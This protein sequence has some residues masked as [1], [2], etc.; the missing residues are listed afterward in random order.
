MSPT[1]I[2]HLFAGPSRF[3]TPY[4][5]S[6]ACTPDGTTVWRPPARRGDID[7]LVRECA[8]PGI[9][10]LADGTFHTYPSV[11]H[12][13][14]RRATESGW[15]VYGLCSMGAIRASEM[16]HLG[17]RPFGRVAQM[18]RDDP[19]L[20]DDEVALVHGA[21]EP[22]YP[23]S[24]PMVHIRAYL[25]HMKS[26][27]LLDTPEHAE[28]VLA[29]REQWYAGRTLARLRVDLQNIARASAL[30]DLLTSLDRFEPY[31]LKQQDLLRFLT[32]KPW[33]DEAGTVWQTQ[34]LNPGNAP[35]AAS[36]VEKPESTTPT[37]ALSSS[38]R[39]RTAEESLALVGPLAAE[40]GVS[41]VVDITWLDR[42][43][44]PV[45]ASIRP[46]APEHSLNVHAGKGS[47]H[48]EAKIGAYME[49][50]E[51]SFAELGRSRVTAHLAT[52]LDILDSFANTIDFIDFCPSQHYPREVQ[53]EDSIG[54]IEAEELLSLHRTVLVPAEL[55]HHPYNGAPG[56]H[57]YTS[58]T[59]G[60]ASGNTIAEAT[61]HGLAEVMERH[62][63]S[64]LTLGATSYWVDPATLSPPLRAMVQRF[65]S[66]GLEVHLRYAPNDFGLAYLS[67]SVFEDGDSPAAIS[68]GMGFHCNSDIAAIRA[69][70]EAAQSRLTTIHGGRD[71]LV[72]MH[73]LFD[74]LGRE[75]EQAMKAALRASTSDRTN[76][77]A[78][79]EIPD[80]NA[81]T[82]AG[83]YTALTDGLKRAGLHH[84]TRVVLTEASCPFQVV[85]IIVPGAE[86]YHY[87]NKRVGPRLLRYVTEQSAR[88]SANSSQPPI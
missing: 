65:E 87:E 86:W 25:Q 28:I 61:V 34:A 62:V 59:N 8:A 60:L 10:G 30:P 69:L 23:L 14:L 19:D 38:L 21:E 80:I 46:N 32:E 37:F 57:L 39:L 67:A 75:K 7:A 27:R 73:L 22:Y 84:L 51:F 72:T 24:E 81:K 83:A 77:I 44:I 56:Q 17:V 48:A 79:G 41:R 45:Y 29:M 9:I 63:E 76:S 2:L 33:L 53:A 1:P 82:I 70:S 47:T 6:E 64:F 11:G 31:R 54:V 13:E 78:F 20:A 36:G 15:R 66:A 16:W 3:G 40:R 35:T 42:L 88:Q 74:E 58:S 71:D 85:R 68:S 18:F 50:V 26:E 49:A 55:V 5:D 43:G 12:A 4:Q 52:P